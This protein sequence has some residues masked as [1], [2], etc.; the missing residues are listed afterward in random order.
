MIYLIGLDSDRTFCHFAQ[1]AK[2]KGVVS[3]VINLRDVIEQGDWH[4]AL[5]VDGSSWLS[6]G[7]DKFHLDPQGNYYC[8][9]I[10]LSS[11]QSTLEM[12]HRWQGLMVALSAWLEMIPGQVVNR[13]NARGDN[14]SK[15]L[16]ELCLQYYGFRV[17]PSITSSDPTRLFEF[18][19]THKAIVKAISGIRADTRIVDSKEFLEF[20][21]AQGPVHLQKFI[22]GYDVRVHVVGDHYQAELVKCPGVDY[23][24]DHDLSEHFPNHQIPNY[25]A[26]QIFRATK[27]FGLEF[28][29]WDFKLTDAGEYYCLEANPMPGYDGYDRRCGHQITDL[30]TDY[31]SKPVKSY[32]QAID[33]SQANGSPQQILTLDECQRVY[34]QIDTLHQHWIHRGSSDSLFCT[35]GAASYLD[36]GT[37]PNAEDTYW[38]KA[39]RYNPV[40]QKNFGWLYERIK[41]YLKLILKLPVSYKADAA[42]PGFH[43]WLG[44]AIPTMP[45]VSLHCDLQY[46]HLNWNGQNPIDFS[47][48]I[49]FTLPIQLPDS[50]GGLELSDFNHLE[51]LDIVEYNK[52]DWDL[53]PRFRKIDYHAYSLGQIVMHSG[54]T[55]HRI[56]LTSSAK[57]TDKRVTLQG[58]GVLIDGIWQI[59]W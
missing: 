21:P 15:P 17:A 58:H 32:P 19:N 3:R 48:A 8:R 1:V 22:A 16:H 30:L 7:T 9:L 37:Y 41:Q 11:V 10:D 33:D 51:F 38:Q 31:L 35:L 57:P 25:L 13:P 36:V 29:G 46:Q 24:L 23:R 12:A 54:H 47:N 2:A 49:S 18:A 14:S 45:I 42:L 34:E 5:P 27:A 44:H 26:Q 43:V 39:H 40:L 50:G 20:T 55:L 53:I 6:D 59:Y 56:A 28:A 4:I 52:I